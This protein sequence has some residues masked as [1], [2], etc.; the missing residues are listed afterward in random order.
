MKVKDVPFDL[1]LIDLLKADD[2]M[3]M[4]ISDEMGLSLSLEEMKVI[5]RHYKDLKRLPTDVEL[6]SLGQV[7]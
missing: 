1:Y 7:F 6:Q 2:A 3:L 5:Q 4:K